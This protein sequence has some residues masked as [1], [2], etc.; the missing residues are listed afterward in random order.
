MA[1]TYSWILNT[2]THNT[3]P[4]RPH[5]SHA[6][7]HTHTNTRALTHTTNIRTTHTR[8]LTHTTLHR[9]ASVNKLKRCQYRWQPRLDSNSIKHICL[10]SFSTNFSRHRKLPIILPTNKVWSYLHFRFSFYDNSIFSSHFRFCLIV[11][12]VLLCTKWQL[13]NDKYDTILEKT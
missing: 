9:G 6:R 12:N 11:K 10:I 2:L 5:T 4:T 3:H 1:L 7:T 8:T 13:L